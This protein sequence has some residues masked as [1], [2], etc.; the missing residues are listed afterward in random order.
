MRKL[1]VALMTAL[2]FGIVMP[3]PAQDDG[4]IILIYEGSNIRYDDKIGFEEL[5]FIDGESSI[6]NVEGTLRRQFLR[7]PEGRSPLEIIRNYE[8][9]V[10]DLGGTIL[11]LSRD[12]KSIEINGMKFKDVFG[13]NRLERGL[14]TSHFTHTAFPG[15]ITEYLA[16]KMSAGDKDV[17]VVV[18]AG[19]GA[20]AA[21]E[22]TRTFFELVT[23]EAEPMDMGMV[24]AVAIGEGLAEQGRIAIY[25]ILFDTGKAEVK[26]ESAPALK[27]IAEYLKADKTRR[28]LVVGH[29]DNTGDFDMNIALS[30]DRAKAV[31]DKLVSEYGVGGDQ[32]KPYGVGPVSPVRSNASEE[33][34]AMNR[35]VEIV[36]R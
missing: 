17:Y 29:T 28:V 25:D 32:L 9:A 30:T 16:G 15:E 4:E 8:K 26:A 1:Q 35:R 5:A 34:R 18:A 14:S 3:A 22:H 23:L 24:T 36:A 6:R 20:W 11:F 21:S 13:K 33:G 7:A 12:P 10:K 2:I 31:V 27:A 19:P